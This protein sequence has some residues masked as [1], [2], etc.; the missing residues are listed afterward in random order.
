[1]VQYA[2]AAAVNGWIA[3]TG[4]PYTVVFCDRKSYA[5]R[6]L[7]DGTV[8]LRVPRR[9]T[10]VQIDDMLS[11]H[12]AWILEKSQ[13]QQDRYQTSLANGAEIPFMGER[14]TIQS[15]ERVAF[16]E[17]NIYL[18]EANRDVYLA[19]FYRAAAKAYLPDRLQKWASLLK[20]A[21]RSVRITSAKGRWGSCSSKTSINFSYRTMMLPASCIDYVIVHE[22]CHLTH[23][24][25]SPAFWAEVE[26]ILPDYRQ[27]EKQIKEA[28]VIML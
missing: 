25:H 14:L 28:F 17:K 8:E 12:H 24:D 20:L 11:R 13:K 16:D 3:G 1:M 27:R 19:E 4:I 18:P 5:V 10:K 15:G 2:A 7:P 6:I 23:M 22:L 21:F 26:R 9:T